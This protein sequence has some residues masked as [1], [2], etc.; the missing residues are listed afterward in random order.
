MNTSKCFMLLITLTLTLDLRKPF[1]LVRKKMQPLKTIYYRISIYIS[2]ER[3][4]LAK[5]TGVISAI[6]RL[7]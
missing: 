5:Y 6:L 4:K 3:A 7:L 2:F 1:I